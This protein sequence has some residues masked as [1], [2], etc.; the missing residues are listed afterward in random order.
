MLVWYVMTHYNDFYGRTLVMPDVE[1]ENGSGYSVE[2]ARL[3][4][5]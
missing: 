2:A 4:N 5:M 3:M 1:L